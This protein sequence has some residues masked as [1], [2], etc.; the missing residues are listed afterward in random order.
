LE[1]WW[2]SEFSILSLWLIHSEKVREKH[3]SFSKAAVT[4]G[5]EL[6]WFFLLLAIY[7]VHNTLWGTVS[8]ISVSLN[9]A[10]F[11]VKKAE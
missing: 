7:I 6:L 10:L 2:L 4:T 5:I 9:G 1:T 8:T 3:D 11:G